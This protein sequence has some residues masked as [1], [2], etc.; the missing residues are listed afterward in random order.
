MLLSCYKSH[1]ASSAAS[2]LT[3]DMTD[4]LEL[5]AYYLFLPHYYDGLNVKA[6]W[7]KCLIE[8]PLH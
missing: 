4:F 5:S 7:E 8:S 1:P 2:A 6:Q 3:T